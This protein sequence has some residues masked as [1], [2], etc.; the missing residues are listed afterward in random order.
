MPND[1][2]LLSAPNLPSL[3]M[4]FLK[5]IGRQTREV[6]VQALQHTELI[7]ESILCDVLDLEIDRTAT[8]R[9]RPTSYHFFSCGTNKRHP[10]R[11]IKIGPS[12][13]PVQPIRTQ[14][15]FHLARRRIAVIQ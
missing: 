12:F 3:P 8:K 6:I 9:T 11:A 1:I 14:D 4:C 13:L 7:S 10:N 5:H 2:L 15:F